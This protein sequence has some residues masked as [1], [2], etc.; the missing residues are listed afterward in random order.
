[1]AAIAGGAVAGAALGASSGGDDCGYYR[2]G[3]CYRNQGHWEREHGINSRDYQLVQ[4]LIVLYALL[5]VG[6]NFATDLIYKA[7]DPRVQF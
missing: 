2:G 5:F 4:T 3:R 1:M 6:I 7:L